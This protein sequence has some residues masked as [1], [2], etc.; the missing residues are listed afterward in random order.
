MKA[1]SYIL[2]LVGYAQ[3]VVCSWGMVVLGLAM[4]VVI[5]IQ[6]FFRF[7]IY[8]PVPWSEEAARYLMIW[9]GLLG[10][11]LAV[12]MG[13]HIGVT[14]AMDRLP[15]NWRM[16]GARLV[17]VCLFMFL[18]IICYQGWELAWFNSMQLSAAMEIPMTIPYLA[19]P[20]GCAMMMIDI[21]ARI[22][23]QLRPTPLGDRTEAFL[24]KIYGAAGMAKVIED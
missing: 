1:L 8:Q 18:G 5:L 6:I 24:D 12:R 23:N 21:L 22:F 9:M 16:G 10:S 4:T 20:V 14:A 13:R 3:L 2:N 11:V 19:I 15:E 17:D 7:V